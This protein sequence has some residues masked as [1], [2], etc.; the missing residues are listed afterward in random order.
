MLVANEGTAGSV[1]ARGD[2]ELLSCELLCMHHPPGGTTFVRQS[3]N[4]IASRE[5]NSRVTIH[6]RSIRCFLFLRV[7]HHKQT[8]A[9]TGGEIYRQARTS[10]DNCKKKDVA[11]VWSYY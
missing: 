4:D 2:A 8:S 11:V 6:C 10:V 3:L 1:F 9:R 7:T 5:T